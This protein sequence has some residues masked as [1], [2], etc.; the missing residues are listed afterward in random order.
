[1]S[2]FNKSAQKSLR[3]VLPLSLYEKLKERC[4]ERGDISKV[5]RSLL[6]KWIAEP[7]IISYRGEESDK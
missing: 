3:V 6:R 2:Q 7:T 4:H 5:V 1:M